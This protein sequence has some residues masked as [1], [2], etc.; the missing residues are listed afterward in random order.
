[1]T[2]EM[3]PEMEAQIRVRAY[4]IWEEQGRPSGQDREHWLQA[5][6]ELMEGVDRG[7]MPKPRPAKKAKV[8]GAKAAAKPKTLAGPNK[9]AA[10]TRHVTKA[11][12][13]AKP[14]ARK[15]PVV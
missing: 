1:M 7:L 6:M 10:A 9:A 12:A 4:H 13:P 14:R 3:T 8:N 5:M 2:Q 11:K 15:A